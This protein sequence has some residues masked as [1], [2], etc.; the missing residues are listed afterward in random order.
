MCGRFTLTASGEELAE[1][2]DL[3]E[4][5]ALAPR[6]N[7]APS[8]PVA[9][10]RLDPAGAR[11]LSTLT[12]GFLPPGS[13]EGDRPFINARAETA[14]ERP[15]FRDAFAERRCLVAAD[16]F[17]EWEGTG[18]RR[19]P[20]YVR[21]GDGRPFGFAGLWE[22]PRLA[23]GL[24]T[25]TLL[26]IAPNELIGRIHDRMP[27]ILAPGDAAAWLDPR[28]KSTADLQPLLRSY[29]APAMAAYRVGLAVNNARFDDP[30]CIAPLG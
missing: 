29:P 2:F 11:R 10:V 5:A 20:W 16:G 17:F 4:V 22:P 7:I 30:S 8:Q 6:Y 18:K 23:E 19:Q 12:W 14:G 26:T 9:V 3:D 27:V 13:L 1:A 21:L 15:S 24:G 25:C 28:R